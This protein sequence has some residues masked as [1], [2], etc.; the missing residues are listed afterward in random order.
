MSNYG[1]WVNQSGVEEEIPPDLYSFLSDSSLQEQ[2]QA[3]LLAQQQDQQR[4]R[5]Q[6][7]QKLPPDRHEIPELVQASDDEVMQQHLIAQEIALQQIQRGRGT[8]VASDA[9]P[10]PPPPTTHVSAFSAIVPQD[11]YTSQDYCGKSDYPMTQNTHFQQEDHH[12]F[13]ALHGAAPASSDNSKAGQEEATGAGDSTTTAT[14]AVATD[15]DEEQ[16][17]VR[18]AEQRVARGQCP[19][20][21]EQLYKLTKSKDRRG[22]VTKILNKLWGSSSSMDATVPS[23]GSNGTGAEEAPRSKAAAAAAAAPEEEYTVRKKPLH[24]PGVVHRGQCVKCS[25][26]DD[27][28]AATSSDQEE[29]EEDANVFLQD[30]GF[31]EDEYLQNSILNPLLVDTSSDPSGNQ[32]QDDSDK[33]PATVTMATY[34][35]PLN[36]YGQRHG[37]GT[38]KWSNGDVYSGNFVNGVRQGAGKLTFGKNGAGGEYVGDWKSNLMHGTGSRR[39]PNGDLYTGPYVQGKR[40]GAQGRFYFS[41]GD[42]Y[43]G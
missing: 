35:G 10:K 43:V 20:C 31:Q 38:L 33:T 7:E 14:T 28:Q 3:F 34:E 5:R 15:D 41:N 27:G 1:S 23:N 40:Q 25:K 4:R 16:E 22:S 9:L 26:V 8:V 13:E 29:D 2:Q 17:A 37:L 12:R 6:Q 30:D 21:G 32:V 36:V 39:F 42:L 18:L 19:S 24:V 11:V